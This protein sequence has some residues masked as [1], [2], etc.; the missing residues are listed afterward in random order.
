[1]SAACTTM[2]CP[3]RP[4][5]SGLLF[6][7]AGGSS[8]KSTYSL[9]TSFLGNVGR[10]TPTVISGMLGCRLLKGSEPPPSFCRCFLP[11]PLCYRYHQQLKNLFSSPYP[12]TMRSKSFSTKPQRPQMVE[13][14]TPA[15]ERH[16]ITTPFSRPDHRDDASLLGWGAV[17]DRAS[18]GSLWSEEECQSHINHPEL[19]D[20][21]L[22]VQRTRQCPMCTCRWTTR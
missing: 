8:A 7:F 14:Q 5:G 19:L 18:T 9:A 13:T 2:T 12:A 22:A 3:S 10:P 11:A 15:V 4:C 21:A 20:A 1:M 6:P 17:A 16:T